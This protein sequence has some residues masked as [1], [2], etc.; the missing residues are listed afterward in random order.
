MRLSKYYIC[1][2]LLVCGLALPTYAQQRPMPPPSRGITPTRA[3]AERNALSNQRRELRMLEITGSK[4]PRKID[5][6]IAHQMQ[7]KKEVNELNEITL[8]FLKLAKEEASNTA[9]H[10]E[11]KE[12]A[13]LADKVAKSSKKLR[14]DLA[15]D[16]FKVEVAPV[17][18]STTE[19]RD[20]QLQKIIQ[21]MDELIE[22]INISN[23]TG[24]ASELKC[25]VLARHLTVLENQANV[26]KDLAKAKH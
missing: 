21:S 15:L 3:E 6:D 19:P 9:N 7:L 11:M 18:F 2:A 4:V 16:D 13:K 8:S 5:T 23:A 10:G 20:Q 14:E 25:K 26:A 1:F 22:Q 17:K 24:T 12:V